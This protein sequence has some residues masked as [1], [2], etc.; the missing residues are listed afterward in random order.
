MSERGI[1]YVATGS[2]YLA[3]AIASARYARAVYPDIGIALF[4]DMDSAAVCEI[5]EPDL[6]TVIKPLNAPQFS[7]RDKLPALLQTPFDQTL[8]LDTDVILA[9]PVDEV[10]DA[11]EYFDLMVA[12]APRRFEYQ[13]EITNFPASIPQLNTGVIAYHASELIFEFFKLW[14]EKSDMS[15]SGSDQ[16]GFRVAL[17]EQRIRYGVMPSEYNFRVPFPQST[18]GLVKIFHCHY[19]IANPGEAAEIMTNINKNRNIRAWAGLPANKVSH[20]PVISPVKIS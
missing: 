18:W 3:E 9:S 16:P 11:L 8:F 14:G 17:L 13:W 12:M 19:L 10:F 5:I 1:V 7:V 6:F 20:R 2:T 15:P 4:A